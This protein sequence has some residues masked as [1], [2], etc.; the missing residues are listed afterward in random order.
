MKAVQWFIKIGTL[1]ACA[2]AFAAPDPK[3]IA[4]AADLPISEWVKQPSFESIRISPDGKHMSMIIPKDDRS[5]FAVLSIAD[6]KAT[7]HVQQRADE[8]IVDA[9]WVSN[10]RIVLELGQRFSGNDAPT[11]TGELAAVDYNGKRSAYLFGYRGKMSTGT[12]IKTGAAE[13]AAATLISDRLIDDRY[14]MTIIRSF[15]ADAGTPSRWCRMDVYSGAQRC[16][17]NLPGR[18]QLEGFLLDDK[19]VLRAIALNDVDGLTHLHYRADQKA[20]WEKIADESKT[21]EGI[22]P[23]AWTGTEQ[24]FYVYHSRARGPTA[25]SK[26][27]PATGKFTVVHQPTSA[28]VGSVLLGT[29]RRTPF[30]VRLLGGRGSIKPLKKGAELDLVMQLASTFPGEVATPLQFSDDGK[31]ALVEVKSDLTSSDYYLYE[32]ASK[33]MTSLGGARQWLNADWMAPTE[34]M[35]SKASDGMELESFLT[36]PLGASKLTP[37]PL[38]VIPHGGPF[39]VKDDWYFETETQLL[40]SRGYAVLRVNFRGSG[41]YGKKFEQAGFKQWGRAMQTDLRDV[42]DVVLKREELDPDRVAIFGASYGGYAALMGGVQEPERYKAVI[43]VVGVTDLELMYT[44]GDI[45]DSLYGVKFM[46]RAIGRAQ[47][48][49]YSPVNHAGKIKAPVLLIHGKLDQRV[50]IA[51]AERMKKALEAAGNAPEW[52]VESKEGHGFYTPENRAAM[53][54]KVLAFLDKHVKKR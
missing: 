8:Y 49:E 30:A 13:R 27:D 46:E 29:D 20:D 19:N 4:S 11:A 51:H 40:A 32:F 52:Y 42:A 25:L 47:L 41:G 7:M 3:V 53:Y 37:A 17:S 45:E 16:E 39:G 10:E 24:Q 14:I 36:L 23:A 44:R 38:V 9:N 2:M 6:M 35:L 5:A 50:P 26:F 12:N 33:K 1:T 34:P 48:A 54:E 28:S 18:G 43:S 31:V 21:S 22:S 15:E